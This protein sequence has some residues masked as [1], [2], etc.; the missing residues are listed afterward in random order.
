MIGAYWPWGSGHGSFEA[1]YQ[2]HE[3]G[4]LLAPFY[5]NHAHN[6]WLELLQTGGVAAG[7]L[8]A[9]FLGMV[10]W[11]SVQREQSCAMDSRVIRQGRTGLI[12]LGLLGFASVFDY[13]LRTPALA[14][15]AGFMLVFACHSGKAGEP[16]DQAGEKI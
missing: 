12:I 10:A 3:P 9:G 2:I 8:L 4:A 11:G 16:E 1:T 13:P 7:V 15:L 6:D 14:C 5:M